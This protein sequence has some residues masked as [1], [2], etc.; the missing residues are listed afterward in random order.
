MDGEQNMRPQQQKARILIVDDEPRNI[1]ILVKLLREKGYDVRASR[2]VD[3]AMQ[4]L[5][6]AEIDLI[7]LDIRM[8]KISGFEFCQ[9]L[10]Q[11]QRTA[12]IPVIFLTALREVEEKVRGLELGAVDYITKPFNLDEV[13]A[14]VKRQLTLK[15]EYKTKAEGTAAS[16]GL[17]KPK[18][19]GEYR[20]SGLAPERRREI[21]KKLTTYF[22]EE[23]PYLDDGCNLESIA[24]K[25]KV[26]RHNLSEAVNVEKNQSIAY[27]INQYRI[28]YFCQILQKQPETSILELSLQSGYNSKS[29]F[30]RWFKTIQKTTP[31]KFQQ[32]LQHYSSSR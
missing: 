7:L 21:C 28:D 15:A 8:P 29:A 4:T 5:E 11:D 17:T 31:K 19:Q 3:H 10:K 24:R 9:H 23:K 18:G 30:N 1:A 22:D 6:I 26:S 32:G 13:L 14:R 20:K 25:L 12:D 16:P 27:M 2:D